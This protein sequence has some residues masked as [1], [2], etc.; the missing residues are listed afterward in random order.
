M[1]LVKGVVPQL[2]SMVVKG[3]H[4]ASFAPIQGCSSGS[5]LYSGLDRG[6]PGH[7]AFLK[8][9]SAL[10][11]PVVHVGQCSESHSPVNEHI[12]AIEDPV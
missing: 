6:V 8:A 12:H 11:D 2:F 1:M 9:R 4:H 3:G 5:D 7:L 10:A